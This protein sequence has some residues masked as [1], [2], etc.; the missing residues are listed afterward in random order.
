M[1]IYISWNFKSI[2]KT[3][4]HTSGIKQFRSGKIAECKQEAGEIKVY[5]NETENAPFNIIFLD[6]L[7]TQFVGN[8]I[9]YF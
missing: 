5:I 6:I 4:Q 8:K 1:K 2:F 9:V 7:Q 3:T